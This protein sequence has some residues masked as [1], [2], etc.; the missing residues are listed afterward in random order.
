MTY[1]CALQLK[2]GILSSCYKFLL[3]M[4]YIY[5]YLKYNNYSCL[6]LFMV[7]ISFIKNR[8][9]QREHPVYAINTLYFKFIYIIVKTEYRKV[10]QLEAIEQNCSEI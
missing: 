4:K 6:L 9:D 2:V 8:R 10:K 7:L 5:I 1:I 3:C